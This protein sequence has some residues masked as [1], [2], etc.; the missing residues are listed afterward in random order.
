MLVGFKRATAI[1][2]LNGKFGTPIV[3]EGKQDNGATTSAEISGLSKEATKV[4]GSDITYYISRK[5][6]GD[7][8]VDLGLLDLPETSADILLGYRQQDDDTD[9]IAYIG[10]ETEAPY[11]ALMLESSTNDG[12]AMLAFYKGVFSR[13]KITINTLDPS[14]TFKP[15][16]DSWTFSSM[17]S[18][19]PGATLGQYV[20]KYYGKSQEMI[21][22]LNQQ[23]GIP[24]DAE[25]QVDTTVPVTGVVA[26]Q[27][28]IEIAVGK[29]VTINFTATPANA[30]DKA[31]TTKS[32]D[33]TVAT[34]DNAG[35][36]TA[37]KE[38]STKV[39]GTIGGKSTDVSV[40]VTAAEG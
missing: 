20:G 35:K 19:T 14:E 18:D 1:P 13:E 37:V 29:T 28:T 5:G 32:D 33:E 25:E 31:L 27:T 24:A 40:T 38:G 8:S 12:K 4:A 9:S 10:N 2:I 26:D 22:T 16:A 15:E 36:V 34:I 3:V 17:A 39:H 11:C 21:N 7:V 23:V 6:V 30:T